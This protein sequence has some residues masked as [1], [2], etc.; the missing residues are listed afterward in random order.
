MTS[1]PPKKDSKQPGVPTKAEWMEEQNRRLFEAVRHNDPHG[2]HDAIARSAEVNAINPTHRNHETPL[3]V[4]AALGFTEAMV[5]LLEEGADVN[6]QNAA[7]HPALHAV[8]HDVVFTKNWLNTVI[9]LVAGADPAIADFG[10]SNLNAVDWAGT[11][12]LADY[13]QSIIDHPEVRP[14]A[15]DLK[16]D[17]DC[18]LNMDARAKALARLAKAKEPPAGA[19][20]SDPAAAK[21]LFGNDKPSAVAEDHSIDAAT[22]PRM[23][24]M[25]VNEEGKIKRMAPKRGSANRTPDGL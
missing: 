10:D 22:V 20:S 24:V 23:S 5:A 4:A 15:E 21:E 2:I 12:K 1:K 7:G 11:T 18:V 14:T 13:L 17:Y 25:A 3:H 6:A 8:A 16:T 9:L 19:S